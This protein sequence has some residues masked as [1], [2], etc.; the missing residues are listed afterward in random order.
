V[1]PETEAAISYWDHRER[2]YVIAQKRADGTPPAFRK[3]IGTI[4][5][6]A[7]V[8]WF[9]EAAERDCAAKCREIGPYYYVFPVDIQILPETYTEDDI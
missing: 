7:N 2:A 9:R 8:Y 6:A 1:T 3:A 4:R 5:D